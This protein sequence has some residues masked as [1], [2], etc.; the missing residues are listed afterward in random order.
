MA[1]ETDF[2]VYG[3]KNDVEALGIMCTGNT[4]HNIHCV[5]VEYIYYM[6]LMGQKKEWLFS[7]EEGEKRRAIFRHFYASCR[8]QTECIFM[9]DHVG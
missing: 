2:G 4:I 7:Y 1:N 8:R 3:M 5:C 9:L 6:H